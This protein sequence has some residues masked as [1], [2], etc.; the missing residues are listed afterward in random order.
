MKMKT[1]YETLS[2]PLLPS[3]SSD[4]ENKII[5][6]LKLEKQILDSHPR[7]AETETLEVKLNN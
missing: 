1:T 3:H 4:H 7:P 6:T 2:F 5:I